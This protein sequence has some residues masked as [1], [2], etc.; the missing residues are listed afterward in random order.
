MPA[1]DEPY[2]TS[3]QIN[4]P[5]ELPDIL[6][7]F[8]KA[9]IRTQPKDV[10]AWSAAYFRSLA[11]GETPPVK[12]RLEMPVA[13]QKT[14]TGLTPG[15]LR[16][17][18]KQLG[19]KKSVPLRLIEDKWKDLGLPKEQFDE[20]TRIGGF[21][22]TVDW[23]KFFSLACSALGENITDAMVAICEIL[24]ADPEGGA[25]RIPYPLFQ[26]LYRYLAEVDGEISQEH[27]KTVYGYLAYYVDKQD[28]FVQP[29]NFTTGDCP[30][31]SG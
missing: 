1:P 20:L 8:T 27:T 6:K 29:R 22:D 14:D 23:L 4:I 30:K 25:A 3:E 28:G 24:T 15:L 9:A 12:E 26:E 2:Y 17:L 5:P 10:L 31:L 21:S 19:P 7:Q 18:N 16:V 13:T 11:N